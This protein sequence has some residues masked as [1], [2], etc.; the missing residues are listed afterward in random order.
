MA[1]DAI[2]KIE[3]LQYLFSG[4]TDFDEVWQDNASWLQ[5]PSANKITVLVA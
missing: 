4:L 2:L 1:A 5:I 3:K